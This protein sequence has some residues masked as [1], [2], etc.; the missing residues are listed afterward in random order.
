MATFKIIT[1]HNSGGSK[2]MVY[3][4]TNDAL[5]ETY[6]NVDAPN[7]SEILE[8]LSDSYQSVR[9]GNIITVLNENNMFMTSPKGTNHGSPWE[10][11]THIPFIAYGKNIKSHYILD[12]PVTLQDIVPTIATVIGEDIPEISEGDV[13]RDLF[14]DNTPQKPKAVV[15][16]VMD[17]LAYRYFD[18]YADELENVAS[19][20]KEGVFST[21]AYVTHLPSSTAVSHTSIG[22]GAYPKTHGIVGNDFYNEKEGKVMYAMEG[23]TPENIQIMTFADIYDQKHNNKV[24]IF[25]LGGADRTAIGLAGHGS[26]ISGGDKDFVFWYDDKTGE[27]IT[28][29]NYY[30]VP[31]ILKDDTIEDYDSFNKSWLGHKIDKPEDALISPALSDMIGSGARKIIQKTVFG[32]EEY[33]DLLFINFKSIDYVGHEYG[34]G[35]ELQQVIKNVDDNIGLIKDS[36]EETFGDDFVLFITADH[37]AAASPEISGVG[38]RINPYIFFNDVKNKFGSCIK[39]RFDA[40][41]IMNIYVDKDLALRDNVSLNDIKNYLDANNDV[42]STFTEDEILKIK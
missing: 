32:K 4:T 27:Y 12:T 3:T 10:Y 7:R 8:M 24:N 6:E 2:L 29:N 38:K 22:T 18:N 30:D 15:V 19:I 39:D 26:F 1:K 37:G 40:G 34:Q 23:S 33:T 17:Q 28:N 35:P 13:I 20:G 41:G 25:S 42:F 36:L 11:D 31:D 14:V 9:S 21:N 16:I 5:I